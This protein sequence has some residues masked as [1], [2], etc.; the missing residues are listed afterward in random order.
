[1]AHVLEQVA[2]RAAGQ[3]VP[4]LAYPVENWRRFKRSISPPWEIDS[5]CPEGRVNRSDSGLSAR[6]EKSWG[7]CAPSQDA[8]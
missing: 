3:S 2:R 4:I 7:F 5:T 6:T 1:V 8:A